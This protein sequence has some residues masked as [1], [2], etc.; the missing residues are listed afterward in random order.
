M[1]DEGRWDGSTY[2]CV[3]FLV[4]ECVAAFGMKRCAAED[5]LDTVSACVAPPLWRCMSCSRTAFLLLRRSHSSWW[6]S[7]SCYGS[8]GHILPL[9]SIRCC[10]CRGTLCVW[11][12]ILRHS[13]GPA[14]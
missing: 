10:R 11:L 9:S 1:F 14:Y 8:G 3:G 12:F 2:G 4:F 7:H 5:K 13:H 6:R